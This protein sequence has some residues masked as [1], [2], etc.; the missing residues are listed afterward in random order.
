MEERYAEESD[1]DWDLDLT[2]APK[3]ND[4]LLGPDSEI[5]AP[6]RGEARGQESPVHGEAPCR[7]RPVQREVPSPRTQAVGSGGRRHESVCGRVG[8]DV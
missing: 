3:Q 4:R 1:S 5:L 2:S 7:K 8:G 6:A